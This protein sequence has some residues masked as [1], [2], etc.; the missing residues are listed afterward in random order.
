MNNLINFWGIWWFT[1]WKANNSSCL[2]QFHS[3]S[4]AHYFQILIFSSWQC[5]WK[6]TIK[7]LSTLG[8]YICS[9]LMWSKSF[10]KEKVNNIN[11]SRAC[12]ALLVSSKESFS[13]WWSSGEAHVIRSFCISSSCSAIRCCQVEFSSWLS[14]S[15]AYSVNT[16]T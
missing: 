10:G 7:P 11:T 12:L 4:T 13:F 5:T 2:L 6:K 14:F 9:N 15:L 1:V 8:I 16:H 3:S